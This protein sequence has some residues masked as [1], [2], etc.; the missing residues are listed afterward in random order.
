MFD[1]HQVQDTGDAL[2]AHGS[3]VWPMTGAIVAAFLALCSVGLL[4]DGAWARVPQAVCPAI[5][6]AHLAIRS[7]RGLR[8]DTCG[9]RPVGRLRRIPWSGIAAVEARNYGID[10]VLVKKGKRISLG[11]PQRFLPR[12]EELRGADGR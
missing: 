4:M 8:V 9:V 7:W 11:L 3:R 2:V 1:H 5:L 10:V 6:L 12:V